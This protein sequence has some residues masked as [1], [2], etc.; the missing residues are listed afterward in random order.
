[1]MS[2]VQELSITQSRAAW[3]KSLGQLHR[4]SCCTKSRKEKLLHLEQ[5]ALA[6]RAPGEN[7]LKQPSQTADIGPAELQANRVVDRDGYR[8]GEQYLYG[9]RKE[10]EAGGL[11]FDGRGYSKVA[12]HRSGSRNAV[13]D[14][15]E[16]NT[17]SDNK[18]HRPDPS[19][20][21]Y[22]RGMIPAVFAIE[23]S[24]IF[25]QSM[26]FDAQRE[27]LRQNFEWDL[28]RLHLAEEAEKQRREKAFNA[29][30]ERRRVVASGKAA[31]AVF[32][33]RNRNLFN[34]A[35]VEHRHATA[36]ITDPE[37]LTQ[38]SRQQGHLRVLDWHVFRSAPLVAHDGVCAIEILAGDPVI[39][40]TQDSWY[41]SPLGRVPKAPEPAKQ[42]FRDVL[43]P[44]KRPV[45]ERIRIYPPL[46]QR[47]LSEL[48]GKPVTAG[49]NS[50]FVFL[51]PFKALVYREDAL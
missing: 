33:H 22:R 15:S 30:A 48:L 16:S 10:F 2:Y 17:F 50:E 37:V 38:E 43:E 32:G 8:H 9:H 46:L 20:L 40:N 26:Y 3:M 21:A 44:G 25:D 24:D 39:T 5:L 27:R 18:Y 41:D 35:E 4:P 29:A 23:T 45:P 31:E 49:E 19:D 13:R 12:T 36:Q 42:G 14:M 1:M 7:D 47:I 34:R 51:R 6:S 28:E 11:P